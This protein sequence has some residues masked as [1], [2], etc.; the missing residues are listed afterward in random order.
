MSF[1]I[2]ATVDL[3]E[4]MAKMQWTMNQIR[5]GINLILVEMATHGFH[6][7]QSI[8]PYRTGRLKSSIQVKV[9]D[10]EATVGPT[11][12][13]APYLEYGTRA[14]PG[15]YV[16]AI[17]KRLVNPAHPSFGMHPG[18]KPQPFVE[19]TRVEMEAFGRRVAEGLLSKAIGE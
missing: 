9:G 18:I 15:R 16:P 19:P 14:S 6:F 4:A 7:M 1:S 5:L 12:D 3:S 2:K 13:Y 17:G 10:M 8:A 11:V